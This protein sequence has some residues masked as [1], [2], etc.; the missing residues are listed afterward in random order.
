M[1]P[2]TQPTDVLADNHDSMT[3]LGA[4]LTSRMHR[5][6]AR[7]HDQSP[8]PEHHLFQFSTPLA[9]GPR[10][11]PA[12]FSSL[13]SPF[14]LGT[15]FCSAREEIDLEGQL[16]SVQPWILINERWAR[17]V[18]GMIASVIK[19]VRGETESPNGVVLSCRFGVA[20]GASRMVDQPSLFFLSHAHTLFLLSLSLPQRSDEPSF[21]SARN[22]LSRVK[23]RVQIDVLRSVVSGLWSPER[24]IKL[25]KCRCT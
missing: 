25:R 4:L 17:R 2:P 5:P 9:A 1:C 3:T 7:K 22:R 12:C 15:C 16:C 19:C 10:N 20:F 6:A 11:E 21:L 23:V 14:G 24:R 8:L 13:L 18:G